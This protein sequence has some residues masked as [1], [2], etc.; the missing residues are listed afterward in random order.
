MLVII[1]FHHQDDIFLTQLFS[2]YDT[3]L[4]LMSHL[5][6]HTRT[7]SQLWHVQCHVPGCESQLVLFTSLYQ[8]V[9]GQFPGRS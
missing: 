3:D 1:A 6:A 8:R 4:N 5:F 9:I 7:I 2:N